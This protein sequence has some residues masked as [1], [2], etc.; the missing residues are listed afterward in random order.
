MIEGKLPDDQLKYLHVKM[1]FTQGNPNSNL[2]LW[3]LSYKWIVSEHK[4][5]EK[6]WVPLIT[7]K[8]S[9]HFSHLDTRQRFK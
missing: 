4:L 2:H 6:L 3:I 9:P 1:K 8:V 7:V 5:T